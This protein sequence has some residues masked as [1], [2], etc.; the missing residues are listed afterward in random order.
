MADRIIGSARDVALRRRAVLRA[1]GAAALAAP[2]PA[3]AQ[4]WPTRPIRLVVPYATG[5][6]PDIL[7]RIFAQELPA[8]LGAA[9]VVENRGG[10]G[11]SIGADHVAKAAADGYT[12]L[13]TTTATHCINPALY[14]S[15]P[16][17]PL[18]DFTPIGLVARTALL[19]AVPPSL[20]AQ[21][22][23]GLVALARARP[24]GLSFASAGAGTMQHITAELFMSRTGTEMVHIP[25]RGTGQITADML[26]GRV[27]LM[28]NSVAAFLPLVQEGKLRALGVTTAARSPAAPEIPTI[29]ESGLPGFEA[30]AW[31]AVY[32]PAG[33]PAPVVAR[34]TAAL[35]QAV[36]S[37]RVRE[38]YAALGLDPESSTPDELAA[39]TR[40]DLETWTGVIRAN[41]IRA[42]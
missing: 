37:P 35:R 36:A 20:P 18:R 28:F 32:G 22:V 42:E 3:R 29:A 16:Y 11:G 9:L 33:L 21:D 23:A 25:Y 19:L 12:L 2:G 14:P 31:Y 39:I 1:L 5:G 34:A 4:D 41:N 38:R 17:D 15:L 13:L 6:A 24:G 40:R 10:Q 30:S 26:S 27:Q 8:N 7:G